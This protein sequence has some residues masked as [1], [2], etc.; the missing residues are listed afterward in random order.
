MPL[1]R[2]L[3]L[4]V[5]LTVFS[6]GALAAEPEG[7]VLK[8]STTLRVPLPGEA[9]REALPVFVDADQISGATEQYVEASGQVVARRLDENLSADWMRYDQAEDRLRAR[10]NVVLTRGRSRIEADEL[11]LQLASHLGEMRPI[12]YESQG[13][14]G[15]YVRGAAALLQFEG[16]D[17][18]R[19]S[20]ASYTS[21]PV[22]NDD[23]LLRTGDLKL[24]YADNIGAARNVRVEYLGMPI[25][26]APWMNFGLDDKRK[27]GF[28]TPGVGVSDRRGA[29]IT[30]PWYWNI[31]PNHDATITPHYM[32]KRGLQLGAEFRYLDDRYQGKLDFEYL[33]EDKAANRDRYYGRIL[34]SQQFDANWAGSLNV[35]QASDDKYFTDLSS[36]VHQTAQANLL[37]EGTLSYNGGWWAA[38]GR[39]Q[40]FQ[41]LSGNPL[42][43]RL[44]QLTLVASRQRPQGYPVD[45]DFSSEFV[46]FSHAWAS[47]PEGDRFHAYPSV[48][49]PFTTSYAHITPKFGWHLTRYDLDRA[50]TGGILQETRSLPVFTLDAGLEFEREFA[51]GGSPFVQTLEP[52]LY[53]VNIPYRDQSK[54]PVF[55]SALLDSSLYTIFS[56][57]QYAGVDRVNDANQ[58]TMALT[59]RLLDNLNG[60]ERIQLT[61]GQRYY[62]SD[63]RVTLPGL[64]ARNANSSD[65]LAILSGQVTN[66]L[67]LSG[68]LQHNADTG[69]TAR[70]GL[71]AFYRD[72]P[73][74]ALNA[75]YRYAQGSID[76]ID[77]S[78]QWP[79]SPMWY[80]IGRLNY[81]FRDSRV[82]EALGGFEHNAGCWSLRGVLHRLALTQ[83][84]TSNAFFIQ[85]ELRDLTKLGPNPLDLLKRSIPG[86]AKS[87]EN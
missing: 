85:L 3:L 46:R 28:L 15:Q 45:I 8:Q 20:E 47:E 83:T 17:R 34:H 16:E 75:D 31:A 30:A 43:S 39:L 69:E 54:L 33:P 4:S 12:R 6:L 13:E 37:K 86:Y 10:G 61:V 66:R 36:V 22:G 72:G 19:L 55:D 81:S 76:Q 2:L 1:K 58:I 57:N 73:G 41:T 51:F 48:K 49:L 70:F 5:P 26:F 29:E 35:S 62:F 38:N 64:A 82:I 87:D 74:R 52:R 84:E 59:S 67:R 32:S 14:K 21:C 56:E 60:I 25:L 65:I 80:G 23:W 9:G 44:P 53:Y 11:Q 18:Y 50:A 71:G 77:L 24:D 79:L 7:I 68:N 27:S 78:A 63:Q 40:S 42:Y